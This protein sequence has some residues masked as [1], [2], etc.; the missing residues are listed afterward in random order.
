M[1][2]L[3]GVRGMKRRIIVEIDCEEKYCGECMMY[4]CSDNY[5]PAFEKDLRYGPD[6]YLRCPACRR[7]EMKGRADV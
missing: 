1:S 2:V 4:A 6:G 3:E 5:C 7:A